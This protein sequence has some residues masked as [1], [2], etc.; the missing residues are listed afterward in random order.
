MEVLALLQFLFLAFAPA[1]AFA[2]ADPPTPPE[3]VS[4]SVPSFT[5]THSFVP[6]HTERPKGT[7]D[8]ANP[9]KSPSSLHFQCRELDA[10]SHF[11]GSLPVGPPH[12]SDSAIGSATPTRTAEPSLATTLQSLK[13]NSTLVSLCAAA[14]AVEETCTGQGAGHPP[15]PGGRNDTAGGFGGEGNNSTR[16]RIDIGS[17]N[18]GMNGTE[19]LNSTMVKVCDEF[20]ALVSNGNM[21]STDA[22]EFFLYFFF[23]FH[24]FSHHI[25][26]CLA[27]LHC[28]IEIGAEIQ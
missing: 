9:P 22:G 21:S 12:F 26:F 28:W 19:G 24:Y 2:F 15:P 13:S 4:F 14:L 23:D 8:T 27:T 5:G 20:A 16:P 6:H 3:G 25:A 1:S 10:L 18:E 7:N 17:G 11:N